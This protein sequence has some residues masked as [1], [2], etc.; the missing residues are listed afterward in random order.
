MSGFPA[1]T[2]LSVRTLISAIPAIMAA[3]L[4]IHGC[5]HETLPGVSLSLSR[6]LQLFVENRCIT[7]PVLP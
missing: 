3:I 4:L 6:T 2:L 5:P 1:E 7:A